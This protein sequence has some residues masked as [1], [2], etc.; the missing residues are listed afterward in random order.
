MRE[1]KNILVYG[2]LFFLFSVGVI[3]L[4]YQDA[5]FI[6]SMNTLAIPVFLFTISTLIVKSNQFIRKVILEEV[7]LQEPMDEKLDKLLEEAEDI[8]KKGDHA[9]EYEQLVGETRNESFKSKLYLTAL[10]KR[11]IFVD[12]VGM[13]INFIAMISFVLCLL[14]IMGIFSIDISLHWINVFSLALVFFDFFVLD[15]WLK[16]YSDKMKKKLL[17]A[18]DDGF[19]KAL[20]ENNN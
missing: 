9:L 20:E 6:N 3:S 16:S 8:A 1:Q 19:N 12:R 11:F 17:D 2:F 5:I 13:F 14:S 18:V 7:G 4:F 10:Y 15:N